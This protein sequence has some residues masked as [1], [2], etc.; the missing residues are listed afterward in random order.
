MTPVPTLQAFIS[1]YGYVALFIGTFLEGETILIIAGFA[2]HSGY[3]Q[4]PMV[5]LVAFVGSLLGDQMAFLVGKKYG[6]KMV[7]RFPGLRPRVA[8]MHQV[9]ARYHKLIMVGFRFVYGMR[10]LTPFVLGLDHHVRTD[11]CKR[12]F[13]AGWARG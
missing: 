8:R 2:A 4:L 1:T 7:A 3:L 12:L 9:M 13:L 5:M 11:R 10:L 6:M